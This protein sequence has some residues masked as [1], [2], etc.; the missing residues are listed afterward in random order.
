[1]NDS[2]HN[3]S[4]NDYDVDTDIQSNTTLAAQ[5]AHLQLA[6]DG[7]SCQACASRIEKVLNKKPSVYDVS[8]NFAGETANVDY[9]PTQTTPDQI[10]EWVNKTGFVANLQAAD[11]LFAQTDEDTATKYPWRLIGLWVCLLPFLIG[12]AGMLVGEGMAW[13]PPV[14]LQFVLATVVQLGFALPFY[15]SAWASIKGGLANM[16]VLVVIGTLTIWAYST[17]LWLTHGDGSLHSLL[18]SNHVGSHSVDHGPAVYFE[19]GVMVIAFVRTGKYLEER[20]KKHSLNSIDLLLSLTPDEVERQQPNGE[21]Q[22]VALKDIQ[23]GDILRAKQ[24]GRVATDGTVTDGSGWCEESHLTGESVPLKKDVGDVLMAGALLENGSLLYRVSAKGSDTKLGDMVQALSDAQGSKANLARL[25]DRVTAIFVPVVVTIALVTFGL[26]WWL[27]GMMDT[28]LMHAVSV[29]VIACP[30]ALGLATPA[31]I[32]A[33][34]G[35]AARHGVWF[36]DAQSL[37]AAGNIDTVVLDKTGTLTIGKPTIVDKVMVDQSLAV[38]D[39]LQIAASIEAHASHPL[40]TAIVNAAAKRN[41][42]LLSVTDVSVIKGAGIQANID[43]LGLVKVGTAEFANLNL[44]K[45]MPKVWQIA[46][47][48]AISINN[49]PLGAFALA[50]DLKADTPQ[51]ITAL[52]NA[53]THVILMSGDKQSVVDHVAGQLGIEQAYGKMSPRDKA[54]QIALLQ[55]AGHK[56]AMA[57]DGVNDAPAMATADA[58]FAM[59]EGTDVA[60][61]SASARLMGESLMHIDAAQ[62]IAKATLRNIKQNLFFAFIYNCLGIPLAA[63]GFLN[64]MIAA[65]AMALSSISVL[66]N[67]LRLTRFKTEVEL[68]NTV[69]ASH[70][71][72]DRP[73]KA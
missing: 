29:L 32:M 50:D 51:A 47:T 48:V 2:T 49:E 14:W 12:M 31:A 35:V 6:I 9:D 52:Q 1:M 45:L 61:H 33:G 42:P 46:S 57:G 53:G 59:F 56:V 64:P 65:A 3:H 67:A 43:G 70:S 26:T 37:E 34:M 72:T 18:Q 69:S 20:T 19:A 27:T 7:M 44:P 4:P 68:D 60:Q 10:T 30:C 55:T 54:S 38:D 40:A 63:F 15:K 21:F 28:A 58:S 62:K 8:V 41:L 16:D 73:K 13:M 71:K 39:V 25:A 17:Y 11:S 36:K 5:R 66:M 24:G 23:V 22:S